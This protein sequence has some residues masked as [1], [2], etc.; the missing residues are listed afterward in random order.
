MSPKY[1]NI[2]TFHSIKIH[3]DTPMDLLDN[4]TPDTIQLQSQELDVISN[5]PLL[6][7]TELDDISKVVYARMITGK[8]INKPGLKNMIASLWQNK[9]G[10]QIEDYSD[11]IIIL[12]FETQA[13]KNRM[14]KGQPWQFA[15]S[16]LILTEARASQQIS[17]ELFRQI[18]FWVQVH[19][20]PPAH[21]SKPHG[22]RLGKA[23]ANSM[24]EFIEFDSNNRRRFLRFQVRLDVTRPLIRG[25]V[26]NLEKNRDNIWVFLRYERLSKFCYFCGCLDHILKGCALL[27]EEIE[28]GQTPV[29]QYD[30]SL[31][32]E[33]LVYEISPHLI[34]TIKEKTLKRSSIAETAM[35]A[36]RNSTKESPSDQNEKRLRLEYA[37]KETQAS[38]GDEEAFLLGRHARKQKE[39]GKNTGQTNMPRNIEKEGEGISNQKSATG[40]QTKPKTK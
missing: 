38:C 5:Q 15:G 35:Q 26:L 22:E 27:M 1:S 2:A 18:T 19:G 21:M 20:V 11:G 7:E 9:V 32:T 6:T 10:V 23:I 13:G 37:R 34:S 30:D 31:K 29:M 28:K 24:G 12:T 40:G 39:E 4:T 17:A 36:T 14:L 25:K 16:Y 3:T 33:G 8:S